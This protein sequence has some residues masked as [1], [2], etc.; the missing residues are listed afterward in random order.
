MLEDQCYARSPSRHV[1]SSIHRRKTTLF[2]LAS[3][4]RLAHQQNLRG[5]PLL[6][7]E[8]APA[9]LV[10]GRRLV[11]LPVLGQ[12]RLLLQDLHASLSRAGA[13]LDDLQSRASPGFGQG[14]CPAEP[15]RTRHSV[16]R[17]SHQNSQFRHRLTLPQALPGTP[18]LCSIPGA[19][20]ILNQNILASV[21]NQDR[22]MAL[23]YE[24]SL[25]MCRVS[26]LQKRIPRSKSFRVCVCV[27]TCA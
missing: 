25:N 12:G 10:R 26:A 27:H 7:A 24:T 5:P 11:A 4:K 22:R 9:R 19:E 14:L 15:A 13:I 21:S 8:R 2:T 17:L 6:S 18:C 16:Q 3:P 1:R 23:A 20:G